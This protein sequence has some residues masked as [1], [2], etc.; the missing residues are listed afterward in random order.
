M[1]DHPKFVDVAD[2]EMALYSA[3]NQMDGKSAERITI[4]EAVRTGLVAN[5]TL[6]YFMARIQQFLI[7][8][9]ILPERL[10]FR[11]HMG[12]EIAHYA[13]DCW[14]AECLTSYGWIECVGCADRSAYDLTQH[15]HATG[16]RLAAEKKLPESKT[17][18]VTEAIPNKQVLGKAFKRDAK[19]ISELLSKL[20]IHDIESMDQELTA[21]DSY[22]LHLN[23]DVTITL[24]REMVSMRKSTKT[25]HVEE[26]I[27]SVI[28]PSFGI[29]RIMYALLEHR[30]QMREGD[31][32]RC[33]F[34]LPPVVAPLKCSVLPL[35]N[36]QEFVPFI[37][38]ICKLTQIFIN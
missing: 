20:S 1:K 36:N 4:G 26:I 21:N 30:F 13:C 25:V 14:D 2:Y 31:E 22:K 12:N 7:K 6:G 33:Y 18:E 15:T 19:A 23:Q 38:Q 37:K 11:Q 10:R 3:C 8:V 34:S 32:Q 35:S 17:I 27:P 24:N 5:E 29:G 16:V 28:E 9:G